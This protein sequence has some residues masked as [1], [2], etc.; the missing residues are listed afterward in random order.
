MTVTSDYMDLAKKLL[1]QGRFKESIEAF[2][3]V[4][5]DP[6]LAADGFYG[7]GY[8]H[9]HLKD[10]PSATASFQSALK[11]NPEHA[12]SAFQLG[13]ISRRLNQIP[14]ALAFYEMTLRLNNR[15]EDAR[16]K[17]KEL[18]PQANIQ[19]APDRGPEVTS[20]AV[21]ETSLSEDADGFIAV[22]ESDKNSNSQKI[23]HLIEACHLSST[24]RLSAYAGRFVAVMFIPIIIFILAVN[25][26]PAIGNPNRNQHYSLTA[27]YLSV[28]FAIGCMFLLLIIIKTKRVEISEGRIVVVT[29]IFSRKKIMNELYRV[30]D[31]EVRQ[32]FFNRLTGDGTLILTFESGGKVTD[33]IELRGNAKFDRLDEMSKKLR[34]LVLLLRTSPYGTGIRY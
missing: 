13:E 26:P 11:I 31:I 29:G 6:N 19:K 5:S 17:I 22:L 15:H 32:T 10:D 24:P 18:G 3:Q 1:Q 8:C 25:Y 12:N 28:F 7:I 23:L 34:E 20:S 9:L 30:S 14:V 4:L 33:Q 21:A 27:I 16:R 2:K